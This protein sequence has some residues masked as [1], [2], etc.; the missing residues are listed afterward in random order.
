MGLER[1]VKAKEQK[2]VVRHIQHREHAIGKKSRR[3]RI[4]GH[5]INKEKL[6]RWVKEN[7]MD[8]PSMFATP[9]LT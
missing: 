5:E 1:N 7:L 8:Q 6:L 3:V 9:P 2:A 4:R